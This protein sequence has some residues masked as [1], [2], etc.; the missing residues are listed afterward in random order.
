MDSSAAIK[1]LESLYSKNALV[2]K[3]RENLQKLTEAIL[4]WVP[5]HVQIFGNEEADKLSKNSLK[6]ISAISI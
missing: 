5:G 6:D 3:I 1:T 2:I 4:F